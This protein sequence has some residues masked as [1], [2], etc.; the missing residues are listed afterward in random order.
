[1]NLTDELLL[2]ATGNVIDSNYKPRHQ[3]ETVE[4]QNHIVHFDKCIPCPLID[5]TAIWS[6]FSMILT[7]ELLLRAS[8]VRA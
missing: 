3:K 5:L 7:K 8:A 1:M 2:R 6:F 4:Q